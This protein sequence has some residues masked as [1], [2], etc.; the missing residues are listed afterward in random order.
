ML[1]HKTCGDPVSLGKGQLRTKQMG[2]VF[3]IVGVLPELQFT[4]FVGVLNSVTLY[5]Q[6]WK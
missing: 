4:G 3:Y 5:N 2:T 1:Q 6:T